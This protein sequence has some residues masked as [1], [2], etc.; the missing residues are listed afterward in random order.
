MKLI[1]LKENLKKGLLVVERAVAEHNNLPILKHLFI[2]TIG[3]QIKLSTT[4][5]EL[6]ITTIIPGKVNEEGGVTVPFSLFSSIVSNNESERIQLSNEG[7][8]IARHY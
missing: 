3:K 1:I 4:N 8:G 5:L 6:G 2:T 7:G